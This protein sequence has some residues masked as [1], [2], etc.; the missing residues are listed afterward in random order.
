M[1]FLNS[2][3]TTPLLGDPPIA[4]LVGGG[5]DNIAFLKGT[6]DGPNADEIQ[7]LAQT[8][9]PVLVGTTSVE[10]SERL[11]DLLKK[12]GEYAGQ[13]TVTAVRR[14]SDDFVYTITRHGDGTV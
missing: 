5:T 4:G 10:K 13:E 14:R 6:Q 7:K 1:I 11:S 8:G 9:Q 3:P 12:K 2:D